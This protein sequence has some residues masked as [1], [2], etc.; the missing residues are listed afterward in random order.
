MK[1]FM[2]VLFV[3]SVWAS[4]FAYSLANRPKPAWTTDAYLVEVYDGDTMTLEVRRQIKVRMLD[5]WAPEI[6][7]RDAA[8]K[9]K[10]FA[11]RDHLR[12]LISPGDHVTL[13]VPGGEDLGKRFSFGRVLGRVWADGSDDDLSV[14]QVA[15]GHATKAK[16]Q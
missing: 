6:R 9:A 3:S 16:R 5:C 7:T 10:G 13:S 4:M 15:A 8:E 11:A 14:Q 12:S 2:T 1:T